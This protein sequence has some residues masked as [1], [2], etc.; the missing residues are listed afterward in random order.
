MKLPINAIR[1]DFQ[2]AACLYSQKVARIAARLQRGDTM[3]PIAVRYD[4]ENYW[5]QDGFHRLEAA[6]SIGR[7]EIDAEVTPGTLAD[8]QAEYKRMLEVAEPAD[9]GSYHWLNWRT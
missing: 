2:K 1:L 4:G 3:P 6:L 5:L 8:I 9:I 7:D